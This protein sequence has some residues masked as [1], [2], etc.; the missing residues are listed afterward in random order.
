M[1][2]TL[3]IA[4]RRIPDYIGK[5]RSAE[6][7]N[8]PGVY[9]YDAVGDTVPANTASTTLTVVWARSRDGI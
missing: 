9:Y 3:A 4:Q 7:R 5:D 8:E 6:L 1:A 2:E